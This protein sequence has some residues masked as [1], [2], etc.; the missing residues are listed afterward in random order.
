MTFDEAYAAG[1]EIMSNTVPG[2][3]GLARAYGYVAAFLAQNP[4]M[5]SRARGVV[6][7]EF[8]VHHAGGFVAGRQNR[9]PVSPGTVPDPRVLD[10]LMMAYHVAPPSL[11]DAI[12][13]HMEA[14]GAENFLGWILE[15]YIASEAEPLGWVWCSG[16]MVKAVDFIY[17][18]PD[19]SWKLLQ[20]KNRSNSENSS[21]ASVRDGTPI[22]I[23]FRFHANTGEV[24]WN[25]F[26]DPRLHTRL[27]EEGFKNCIQGCLM[28]CAPGLP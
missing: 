11:D 5:A 12:R 4:E 27:T 21:S 10:I 28:R 26:P 6:S 20:V 13:Y 9:E 1:Y 7:R 17:P 8:L 23:W 3:V 19:R 16:A 22:E 2:D 24:C 14:M 18:M 15:A 25:L